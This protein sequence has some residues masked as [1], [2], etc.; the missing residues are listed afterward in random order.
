MATE[1]KQFIKELTFF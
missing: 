1:Q